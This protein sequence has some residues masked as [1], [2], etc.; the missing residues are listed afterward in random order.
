MTIDDT[1]PE[2]LARVAVLNAKGTRIVNHTYLDPKELYF[3]CPYLIF[4]SVMDSF[5]LPLIEACDSG[6]KILA[7]ALPYVHDVIKP[8]L[9]FDPYDKVSIADAVLKALATELSFP[10]VVTKDEVSKLL[11]LLLH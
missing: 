7:A 11:A 4:P 10:Q 1:A 6:M 3:N 5:G 8:S 9:T 2:L